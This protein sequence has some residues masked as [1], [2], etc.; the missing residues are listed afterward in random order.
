MW[1]VG[2]EIGKKNAGK[3]KITFSIKYGLAKYHSD[4]N[5][6]SGGARPLK[7]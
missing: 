5:V 3:L 7:V 1:P 6:I 2:G 4:I